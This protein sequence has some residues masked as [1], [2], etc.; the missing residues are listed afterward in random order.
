MLDRLFG[1]FLRWASSGGW[2]WLPGGGGPREMGRLQYWLEDAAGY[3][4]RVGLGGVL[5]GRDERCDVVVRTPE[6]SRQHALLREGADDL[7]LIHLGRNPTR[8][9]GEEVPRQ[10]TLRPGDRVEVPG[11]AFVVVAGEARE[12]PRV[13]HLELDQQHLFAVTSSPFA[14]G[15]G[16]DDDLTVPGWPDAALQFHLAQGALLVEGARPVQLRDR[17][18]PEGELTQLR[19]G[20][21]LAWEDRRLRVIAAGD[22][23]Q[24]TTALDPGGALPIR[25]ELAFLPQGG[26]LSLEFPQDRY[27]AWLSELRADLIATLLSPP[28][29]LAA[30]E[31][32][33]DETLI[34]RVWPG[35]PEKGKRDLNLLVYWSRRALIEAGI[36]G[37]TLIERAP[38]G[39]ATR[40]R[41]SPGARAAVVG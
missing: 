3:R 40:F 1:A 30:G 22:A 26:R 17:P 23:S 27:T 6:A 10:A 8:V 12:Q 29:D 11:G 14:V 2:W 32:V 25:A 34:A 4:V 37:L 13:W 35:R 18:L 7:E 9:N 39:G 41:L 16:G 31:F 5:V 21:E 36:N 33:P 20:D 38:R 15:G 24:A 19:A 28:G